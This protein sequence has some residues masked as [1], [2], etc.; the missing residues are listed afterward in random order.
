M[1]SFHKGVDYT[2]EEQEYP[3]QLA[4]ESEGTIRLMALA[5]AVERVLQTGGVL[6]VDELEQKM[7]P[8]LMEFLVN[9]FQAPSC[10]SKSCTTYFLQLTIPLC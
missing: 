9:K 10:Q 7:H 5:P 2:G 4:D 1:T 3:L 6:L 8:M